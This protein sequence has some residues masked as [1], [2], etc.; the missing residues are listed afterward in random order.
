[1]GRRKGKDTGAANPPVDCGALLDLAG[2]L[3]RLGGN[4]E[5]LGTV[6]ALFARDAPLRLEEL[7]RA[8]GAQ[9]Q[10]LARRALHSLRGMAAAVGA[11]SLDQAVVAAHATARGRNLAD[12][13]AALPGL[14][15]GLARVLER[16][17]TGEG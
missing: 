13:A 4:R 16:I 11:E 9:D 3:E 6:L 5:L 14:E 1:M 17:R 10:E 7:R 12:C 2:A 15:A 8:L